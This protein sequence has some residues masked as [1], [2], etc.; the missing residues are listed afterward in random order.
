MMKLNH[1]K[2]KSQKLD[3]K[4]GLGISSFVV[5]LAMAFRFCFVDCIVVRR[6]QRLLNTKKENDQPVVNLVPGLW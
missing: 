3:V 6:F 1:K 5:F 2:W 4:P